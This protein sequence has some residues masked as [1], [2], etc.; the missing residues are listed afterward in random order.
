MNR[1]QDALAD[2]G[3]SLEQEPEHVDSLYLPSLMERRQ[4]KVADAA[5]NLDTAAF[6]A[7]RVGRDRAVSGKSL[8][9]ERDRKIAAQPQ[10]PYPLRGEESR[11]ATPLPPSPELKAGVATLCPQ[12]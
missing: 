7:P 8:A 3:T 9:R 12:G 10:F 4:G 1:F 2:A 6:I 11:A 5:R